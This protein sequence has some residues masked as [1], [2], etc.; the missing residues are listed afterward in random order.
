[1]FLPTATASALPPGYNLYM[2]GRYIRRV[3]Y[4]NCKGI[5]ISIDQIPNTVEIIWD[6]TETSN[7][8]FC[9]LR[10]YETI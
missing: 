3:M 5:G 1:M 8:F 10:E 2:F 7:D 9:L 6:T 4:D